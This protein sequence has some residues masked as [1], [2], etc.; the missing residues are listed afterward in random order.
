MMRVAMMTQRM[1]CK[2]MM[3]MVEKKMMAMV[4]MLVLM[5]MVAPAGRTFRGRAAGL[6]GCAVGANARARGRGGGVA[7]V[8]MATVHK[9]DMMGCCQWRW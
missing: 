8:M 9:T 2:M 4:S 7:R 1:M 3:M 5:E 6:A